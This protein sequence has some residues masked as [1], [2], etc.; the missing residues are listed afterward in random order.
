MNEHHRLEGLLYEFVRNEL[1]ASAREEVQAH[2]A[3]CG[4]CRKEVAVL[5]DA[6][7]AMPP[8]RE[9][10][11]AQRSESYWESFARRVEQRLPS[12]PKGSAWIGSLKETIDSI[13]GLR[14]GLA[15]SIAGS[16][17]IILITLTLWISVPEEAT[18]NRGNSIVDESSV[19]AQTSLAVKDYFEDSRMLLIGIVNLPPD[20]ESPVDLSVERT[21]ARNLVQ[22]ARYLTDQPIDARSAELIREL[23]RILVELANLKETANI[24]DVDLIRTGVRQENVL[25]KIRMAE[26]LLDRQQ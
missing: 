23:Q 11:S 16:A 6:F 21:A 26:N 25:F 9:D 22:Q 10:A 15:Y 5:T 18:L 7:H 2:L 24:P 1:D 3:S 8:R 12:Q 17:L 19:T 4:P 20:Q 14:P 13:V